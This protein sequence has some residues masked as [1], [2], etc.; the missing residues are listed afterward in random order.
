MVLLARQERATFQR[1]LVETTRALTLNVDRLLQASLNN[2]ESMSSSPRLDGGDITGFCDLAARMLQSYEDWKMIIL[3]DGAGN[4]L[5]TTIGQ[6]G[7]A[8]PAALDRETLEAVIRTRRPALSN[9]FADK[10]IGTSI[11]L[12]SPV[13][14]AGEVKFI[15]AAVLPPNAF[16]GILLQQKL[17]PD[18][19]GLVVDRNRSIVARVPSNEA[20]VGQPAVSLTPLGANP[21]LEGLLEDV[22][23]H[24]GVRSYVAYGRAS[25][26]GWT[27]AL[28]VPTA[29]VDAPFYRSLWTAGGAGLVFLLVGLLLAVFLARRI[30]APV[31]SLTAMADALGSHQKGPIPEPRPSGL[32]EVDVLTQHMLRSATALEIRSLERDRVEAELRR[33]EEFLQR[34]ADLL[35][36]TGEAIIGWELG[37]PMIYWN[38]GAEDLYGIA[39][40]DA[41]GKPSQELLTR[42]F[43]GVE[44]D[45]GPML[46]EHGE[47]TGE[48]KHV[49]AAGPPLIIERHVRLVQ[50][51][52][53]RHL[54]LESNRDITKR[55][56]FIERITTEHAITVILAEANVLAEAMGRLLE[57]IG[58]GLG[59]AVGFFWKVNEEGTLIE[60]VETW[61]EPSRDFC[62]CE[63]NPPLRRGIG[64]PGRVWA[65]KDSIWIADVRQ[66]A[67]WLR[68][69]TAEKDNLHGAFAFPV[70]LRDEV[71]GVI[72]FLSTEIREPD[73]DLLKMVESVG[74]EI[75]QFVERLRAEAALR[76]S[77]E[78]LRNQAQ[79]L[80]RQ[81]LA[82]GRL[83]AAGEL[84][85][86]MAHEFNNPLGIIL[87]F[88]QG[89][90]AD[91]ERTSPNYH[92][93]EIIVEEAQRCSRIVQELLE[94]GRPKEAAFAP[95]DAKSVID[96]TLD[97]ISRRAAES[98]VMT[99]TSIAEGLPLIH[100]DAQQVQQVLLNL[101]LNAI[102]AMPHGG[103]LTIGAEAT[104]SELTIT[105]ADTG[106]GIEPEAMARIFQ[107]FFTAKKRRGLGLGLPICARI[108]KAHGG[109]I[110]VESEPGKGS[111]F[112]IRL[113]V[114]RENIVDTL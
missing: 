29:I 108:V 11:S 87:G 50:E 31:R 37:G 43:S 74:S 45:L 111:I 10:N 38:R 76:R 14:R 107:P 109:T 55:K 56:Q 1:G 100:A 34:Q 68:I 18:W 67:D 86:S 51:R 113:P 78:N 36:L 91:M 92:P 95:T 114:D 60:C 57:A 94:F 88:A 5:C 28:S 46:N 41:V 26:S 3:L 85:A 61:H 72:E 73:Q 65:R 12:F 6:T 102:D 112:R 23:R 24:D 54:V 79:E 104:E 21:A 44:L 58:S 42:L 106:Y 48:L 70:R 32:T 80:E 64:L 101:C 15:V 17:A 4:R 110:A 16:S 66:Q 35:D 20:F 89:L 22:P 2:L 71:L 59:W 49:A 19:I 40:R 103:E 52:T 99:T 96:R 8:A 98:K 63:L 25:W 81:L 62:G 39:R 75:G 93:V 27:V 47:W 30:A 9:L 90:L 33:S 97:L 83:V 105:V 7:A 84:T 82:S 69:A 13:V 53:G 77:E